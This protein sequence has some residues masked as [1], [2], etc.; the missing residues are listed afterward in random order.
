MPGYVICPNEWLD[1]PDI[2]NTQRS[3]LLALA[4]ATDRATGCAVVRQH[5]LAKNLGVSRSTVN[6]AI[7]DLAAMIDS[8]GRPI[9]EIETRHNHDGWQIAHRYSLPAYLACLRFDTGCAKNGH[10]GFKNSESSPTQEQCGQEAEKTV[11]QAD[12]RPT[13]DDKTWLQ[14]VRPDLDASMVTTRFLTWYRRR[15]IAVWSVSQKWR[16]WATHEAVKPNSRRPT[17][18]QTSTV[19]ATCKSVLRARAQM[20]STA[21]PSARSMA[22]QWP[23]ADIVAMV[24]AG[25]LA[26]EIGQQYLN[27]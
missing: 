15:Q 6:R 20:L 13:A 1:H 25:L 22:R 3:I 5:T 18:D 11:P 4:R 23:R 2:T 26:P 16:E 17:Q 7:L 8:S 12:W 19:T 27:S 9:V 10:Q 14:K 24:S 21:S